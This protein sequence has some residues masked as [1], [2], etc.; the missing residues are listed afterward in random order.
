M[1][2]GCAGSPGRA[3]THAVRSRRRVAALVAV[4]ALAT[5]PIALTEATATSAPTALAHVHNFRTVTRW[6]TFRRGARVLPTMIVLPVVSP[7]TTVPVMEFAHGWHSNPRVYASVLRGWASAGF[8]VVAPSSPEMA[9]GKGLLPQGAASLRQ[10]GDLPVV[11]TDVLRM[12]LPV[13]PDTSEIA[14]AG[15]S[16]GACTVADMAFNPRYRDPRIDA[17]LIFSGA[18]TSINYGR[19]RFHANPKPVFI[20]DS[21]D[22][23]FGDFAEA[24]PLY[25]QARGRKVLVAIGRDDRHLAPWTVSTLFHERIWNATIEFASW[26]FTGRGSALEALIADVDTPGLAISLDRSGG[27]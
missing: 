25:R 24:G 14:L 10:A 21:R 20:A 15:H 6:V 13:T 1:P 17:Y 5:A 18:R 2:H 9:R 26:A 11:L 19:A 12:S 8:L 7:G 27:V 23:E 16:E 22:D 4:L 3:H